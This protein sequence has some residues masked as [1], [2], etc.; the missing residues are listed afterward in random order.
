M[1]CDFIVSAIL[2][3]WKD[4]GIYSV[5]LF[6]EGFGRDEFPQNLKLLF[7]LFYQSK[8]ITRLNNSGKY[9]VKLEDGS[10]SVDVNA[11]ATI[12]LGPL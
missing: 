11:F 10:P 8:R 1:T 12:Y 9:D 7:S 6:G 2:L 5:K 3:H 4:S